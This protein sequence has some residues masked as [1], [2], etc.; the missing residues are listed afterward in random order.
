M[1]QEL[2]AAATE[3]RT[4]SYA[5][6]SR[7]HVG[8][9]V[10]AGGRVF[11][12]ANVENAS[13]GLCIC[14]ERNA[15]MAAVLAGESRVDACTVVTD[16]SPPAAPCG[17][18]LQTLREFTRAPESLQVTLVNLAGEQRAY[19]LAELLPHGFAPEDLKR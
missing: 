11:T 17:M 9:A 10:R 19:T 8:A 1:S 2:I 14:A 13:Y 5:P 18:C 7:F 4:R 6:Y 15:I 16:S 12:G 3:A